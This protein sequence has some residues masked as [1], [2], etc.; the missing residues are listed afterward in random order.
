[1]FVGGVGGKDDWKG[2]KVGEKCDFVNVP[3]AKEEE[4]EEEAEGIAGTW[5]RPLPFPS[6]PSSDGKGAGGQ[7]W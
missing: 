2:G 1:M 7:R 3:T 4:E 5:F 6:F